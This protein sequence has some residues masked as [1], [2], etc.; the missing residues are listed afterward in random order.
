M[1]GSNNQLKIN[2]GAVSK[3]L[4]RQKTYLRTYAPSNYLAFALSV[5]ITVHRLGSQG[6]KFPHADNDE[7]GR[8]VQICRLILICKGNTSEGSYVYSRRNSNVLIDWRQYEETFT[9]IRPRY[10]YKAQTAWYSASFKT[11]VGIPKYHNLSR[12]VRK[13]TY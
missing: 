6:C 2:K 11:D 12:N 7:S 13:R 9:E 8:T 1:K 4:Q 3:Q 10:V 5:Q